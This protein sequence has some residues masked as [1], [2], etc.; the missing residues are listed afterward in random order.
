M[1]DTILAIGFKISF[2]IRRSEVGKI[3]KCWKWITLKT[4]AYCEKQSIRKTNTDPP[5]GSAE[6]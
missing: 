6:R 5:S 2:E 4:L 3:R 1:K